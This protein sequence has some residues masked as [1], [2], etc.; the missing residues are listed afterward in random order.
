M[1]V[2]A[3]ISICALVT[4]LGM[5]LAGLSMVIDQLRCADAAR[6][7]ARLLA[8]GDSSLAADAVRT[9]APSRAR[10]VVR[11]ELGGVLVTVLTDAGSGLLPVV[12]LHAEAYATIEPGQG[13]EAPTKERARA[14]A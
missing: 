4:I 10:M 8:R 1:T 12:E 11:Y 2:E 7:A 13:R 14:P 5:V 3:A 6:A 9:L